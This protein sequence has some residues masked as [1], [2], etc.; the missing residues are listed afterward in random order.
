MKS[1]KSSILPVL[2]PGK[3]PE[4]RCGSRVRLGVGLL[5]AVA[6]V[7]ACGSSG[8]SS[9]NASYYVSM[10]DS[11]AVGVQPNESGN[12]VRQSLANLSVTFAGS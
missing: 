7:A 9:P 5:A 3:H 12:S 10:G 11:S 1:L 4:G 6:G 8:A 2:H